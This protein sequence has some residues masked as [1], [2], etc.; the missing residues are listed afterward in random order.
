MVNDDTAKT[1]S[2]VLCTLNRAELLEGALASLA[3]Q[4]INPTSYE[5]LVVDNG[6]SDA[7][8]KV[9]ERYRQVIA[10]FR[11]FSEHRQGLSH[12]RNRGWREG[13]AP[14]VAFMDDDARADRG[15]LTALCDFLDR[16]PRVA[17]CGGPYRPF[18]TVTPPTWFPPEYGSLNLGNLERPVRIGAEWLTG[19]NLVVRCDLLEE[20]G[21]FDPELGMSGT[22]ISYG[23]ETRL[24]RAV[25]ALGEEIWYVPAMGMEH[26]V[27]ADKMRLSWLLRSGYAV[28][29]GAAAALGERHSA[30]GLLA[31]LVQCLVIGAGRLLYPWSV[32]FRR[33]LYYAGYDLV[34]MVGRIV[35][36]TGIGGGR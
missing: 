26:L 19:T 7:T 10:N 27:A 15:W 29:V 16:H 14:Y 18:Y 8:W 2:V 32:P 21:G 31:G 30:M 6:S 23:E 20:L 1:V 9:I 35:E 28:G 11:A 22:R 12:A 36:Y 25:Q 5:V 34:A 3:A 33:R 13:V 4:D 24:L 17:V